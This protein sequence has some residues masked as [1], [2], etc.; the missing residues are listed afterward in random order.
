MRL[1][2]EKLHSVE[3]Q[4]PWRQFITKQASSILSIST[5]LCPEKHTHIM[6]GKQMVVGKRIKL[7]TLTP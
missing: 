6:T 7:N 3:Q 2:K 1:T 5:D 4:N